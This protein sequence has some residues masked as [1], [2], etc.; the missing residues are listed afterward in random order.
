M[1][2]LGTCIGEYA[3][4]AW[5]FFMD[6]YS[7]GYVMSDLGC[8]QH[9]LQSFHQTRVTVVRVVIL[10]PRCPSVNPFAF[11]IPKQSVV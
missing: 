9:S 8:C 2:Q 5:M 10:I 3:V 11:M 6:V 1:S 4:I 7:V